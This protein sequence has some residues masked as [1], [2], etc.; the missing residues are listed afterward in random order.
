MWAFLVVV[1]DMP[2]GDPKGLARALGF[3]CVMWKFLGQL[4]GCS[5]ISHWLQIYSPGKSLPFGEK[6]AWPALF[7]F[8]PIPTLGSEEELL[9]E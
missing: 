3:I 8:P 6:A 5:R 1:T 2:S 4:T 7:H 9:L